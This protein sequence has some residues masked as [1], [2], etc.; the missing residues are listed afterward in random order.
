MMKMSGL[1]LLIFL[2]CA[3][4]VQ[5]QE[6]SRT[7]S[8]SLMVALKTIYEQSSNEVCSVDELKATLAPIFE[9]LMAERLAR[10]DEK[11]AML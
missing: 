6:S 9:E 3:T 11:V 10:N 8:Q 1:K 4:F 7:C 5:P 2:L